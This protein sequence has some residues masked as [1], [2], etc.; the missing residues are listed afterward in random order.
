M[1]LQA[2]RLTAL[3]STLLLTKLRMADGSVCLLCRDIVSAGFPLLTSRL[4]W[5]SDL[6]LHC[7]HL[8]HSSMHLGATYEEALTLEVGGVDVQCI[9]RSRGDRWRSV[10]PEERHL[11]VDC[12]GSVRCTSGLRHMLQEDPADVT[13]AD[14]H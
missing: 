10:Y 9:C 14:E 12:L 7:N 4:T 11:Q 3:H 13:T 6:L 1:Q 5:L 8:I 2:R